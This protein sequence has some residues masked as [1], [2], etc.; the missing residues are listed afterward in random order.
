MAFDPTSGDLVLFGGSPPTGSNNQYLSDTWLWDGI[1]WQQ[2]SATGP[3]GRIEPAMATN[4]ATSTV[5]M[6]GGITNVP[7]GVSHDLNDTWEWFNGNWVQRTS[8]TSPSPRYQAGLAYSPADFGLVLFGGYDFSG[9]NPITYN[10]T[11]RWNG[12]TWTQFQP[13]AAPGA[14][15]LLAMTYDSSAHQLVLF[16]GVD[17]NGH[18]VDATVWNRTG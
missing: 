10:E 17:T 8:A 16:G 11:W 6:F 14:R 12:V 3:V 15:R 13:T 9:A 4:P 1:T 2:S 7:P 5:V 18:P